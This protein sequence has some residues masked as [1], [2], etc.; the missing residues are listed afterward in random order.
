MRHPEL[1]TLPLDGLFHRLE[2]AGFELSPAD[3]LRAWKVL[4]GPGKQYLQEPEQLKLLLGPVLA[5]SA[6]DQ[7]RFS[8]LFD[9]YY[10][11]LNA[12]LDL[13][14]TSKL[15]L[16]WWVILSILTLLGAITGYSVWRMTRP[17]SINELRIAIAGPTSGA[18]GDTITFRHEGA[19]PEDTTGIRWS[20]E[21]RDIETGQLEFADSSTGYFQLI[22]PALQGPSYDKEVHLSIIGAG[23]DSSLHATL[24]FTVTCPSPPQVSGIL[25]AQQAPI[26]ETISF[27][28]TS[29]DSQ[30]LD[31]SGQ[32]QG[33]AADWLFEWSFGDGIQ[34]QG[35]TVRHT[36]Q[37]EGQ[38]QV[39]LTVSAPNDQGLCQRIYHHDLKVGQDYAIL[40]EH[41]LGNDQFSLIA[42]WAWGFWVLLALLGL[43]VVYLWLR[44][45]LNRP[46]PEAPEGQQEVYARFQVSDKAPYFIPLVDH[47]SLIQPSAAS[48][49]FA[50]ALRLRQEGLR[51]V[52][53]IPGSLRTTI[54][55]GGF[56]ALQFRFL[57]QPSEYLFLIDEQSRASHLGQLFKY[58]AELLR[59]QD[60]HLETFFY[61]RQLNRFWN[62]HHPEG[63]SL[64]MIYRLH[65]EHRLVVMGDLHELIDP[66]ASGQPRLRPS[67]DALFRPWR[68]AFLL[69]P[70]PPVSWSYREKL[71]SRRFS[72]FPADVEGIAA[73]ALALENEA[74]PFS[75]GILFEQWQER[76]L[77]VREDSE[78]EH[79]RWKRWPVIDEY[80]S[81]YD[82]A[83]RKWF[84]A[85]AVFPT[86]SWEMTLAI[87]QALEA[88][89]NYDNLLVLA[90]IPALQQDHFDERLRQDMLRELDASSERIARETVRLELQDL[91]AVTANSHAGHHLE[92][93]LAIQEFALDPYGNDSRDAIRFLLDHGMLNK[94]QEKELD[95][96]AARFQQPRQQKAQTKQR[97]LSK[98]EAA[99]LPVREWLSQ[100]SPK[101]AAQQPEHPFF[102][103]DL[104]RAIAATVLYLCFL[105]SLVNLGGSTRLY[106]WVFGDQPTEINLDDDGQLRHYFVVKESVLL[107][108][109]IIYNN[110]GVIRWENDS[111][112]WAINSFKQA[113]QAAEPFLPGKTDQFQGAS[114]PYALANANLAATHYNVA[115]RYYNDFFQN[116]NPNNLLLAEVQ[117]DSAYRSDSLALQVQHARGLIHF[118]RG[119]PLDTITQYYDE[120]AELGFFDTIS[121]SPNLATLLG[122]ERSHLV[123]VSINPVGDQSVEIFVDYL[124]NNLPF[125]SYQLVVFPTDNEGEVPDTIRRD[126]P[127]EANFI[128][129][130]MESPGREAGS[131]EGLTVQLQGTNGIIV[132]EQSLDFEHNWQVV[133]NEPPPV[134]PT[135]EE[136]SNQVPLNFSGIVIDDLSGAV[137]S[138]ARIDLIDLD[139]PPTRQRVQFQATSNAE[140]T[141]QINATLE[142]KVLSARYAFEIMADG[143]SFYRRE[144]T[145]AELTRNT[146]GNP[147]EF[148]LEALDQ[149]TPQQGPPDDGGVDCELY[150]TNGMEAFNNQDYQLAMTNLEAYLACSPE[151]TNAQ[152]LI[153]QT[154]TRWLTALNQQSK[155]EYN[156]PDGRYAVYADQR[157]DR[158]GPAGQYQQEL[159]SNGF[160][161]CLIIS[162]TPSTGGPYTIE[163]ERFNRREEADAFIK[164]RLSPYSINAYAFDR[165]A[166]GN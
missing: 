1:H 60:V 127:N 95:Q 126:I 102:T 18:V 128:I 157:F 93:A 148:R 61:R 134:P 140:G 76:Q 24:P 115:V 5:R 43:G 108:S 53:D 118:Y 52:I 99:A 111:T 79:R 149:T 69:T 33:E 15:G 17:A 164:T 57:T 144:W 101:P 67:Y 74:D 51:E 23:L 92:T 56:P 110:R 88:P 105:F 30:L 160:E 40:P 163:I 116:G 121:Y 32:W 97:K 3:R 16:P 84:L 22:A 98:A 29:D 135:R 58:M 124:T 45:W 112:T 103:A 6:A 48:Q 109:A 41:P 86:P 14:R 143:Y 122:L 55:Q 158:I 107:D 106:N 2:L 66:Y 151:S 44:W 131:S 153:V 89:V 62:N 59:G 34:A 68:Q 13:R 81:T 139:P 83:L 156:A 65:P 38:Y 161:Q 39:Q 100:D 47:N 85:L 7:Q 72:V 42:V 80:L 96:V 27:Q 46:E 11:E 78:T 19:L 12:P 50:D 155:G 87:G 162:L 36:Y 152:R 137:I 90:R 117:L 136:P 94:G 10:A 159:R 9:Q 123:D 70:V 82:P 8:E 138:A 21:Y 37:Q 154:R 120:L 4:G 63:L 104:W 31:E 142:E 165:Q 73:A 64:E 113:L 129:L 146:A 114:I 119:S 25:A 166:S 130:R 147:S 54:D 132:D 75:D 20:W 49:R 71:L 91:K 35:A 150:R 133:T 26:N 28:A 141:F 77:A 145:V 125:D